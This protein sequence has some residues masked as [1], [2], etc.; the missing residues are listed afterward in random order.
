[1]DKRDNRRHEFQSSLPHGSD[2]AKRVLHLFVNYFNRRSLTG[3][4]IRRITIFTT[5]K[6]SILAPSRERPLHDCCVAG[7]EYFNPRSLT[8]ATY[9]MA[10]FFTLYDISILA[11]SRE[12]R[13]D[14]FTS[15]L[16]WPQFQSSLPH[17]RDA[18][19]RQ[20]WQYQQQ[21]QSSL[22]HGSDGRGNGFSKSF[23]IS[24]LAPS[25]E[26]HGARNLLSTQNN[27]NPRSLTGA[28][29]CVRIDFCAKRNFNPRSLTGA[30]NAKIIGK[31]ANGISILAPSR[32]RPGH[33]LIHISIGLF[34]S[35]LPHGSDHHAAY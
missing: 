6:I 22:P 34:Q 8:G 13:H 33:Q 31:A 24:I 30:T 29:C 14:Y 23:T 32:E 28:T 4:T 26:R 18:L 10:K 15:A 12:R 3:A 35:S 9:A 27:F 19:Q 2:G 21:F 11:P 5:R 7:G 16:P 20:N 25:R 1:M 17:G